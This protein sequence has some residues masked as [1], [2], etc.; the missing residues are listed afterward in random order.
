MESTYYYWD[1]TMNPW[2]LQKE[3]PESLW[4]EMI[5]FEILQKTKNKTMKET[6]EIIESIQKEYKEIRGK[7]ESDDKQE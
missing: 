2:C 5:E 7:L 3:A 6:T 4:K 1:E